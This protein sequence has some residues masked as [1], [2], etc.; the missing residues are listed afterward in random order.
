MWWN[1]E[2]V[3]RRPEMA[4]WSQEGVWRSRGRA[5]DRERFKRFHRFLENRPCFTGKSGTLGNRGLIRPNLAVDY[6][7]PAERRVR[8][9]GVRELERARADVARHAGGES[10]HPSSDPALSAPTSTRRRRPQ[11]ATACPR[12]PCARARAPTVARAPATFATKNVMT[13][14]CVIVVLQ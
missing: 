4:W 2:G 12:R 8:S 14:T 7:D 1:R 5:G 3:R 13:M 6:Q 11:R 9:A 10:W